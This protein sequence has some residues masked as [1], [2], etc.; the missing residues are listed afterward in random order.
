MSLERFFTDLYYE[1]IHFRDSLQFELQS[2]FAPLRYAKKSFSVSTQEFYLFI[3]S[4]LQINRHT[5]SKEQFY[6]DRTNLIRFKTPEFTFRELI[7]EKN[8][9]SPLHRLDAMSLSI[10]SGDAHLMFQDELKLLANIV[11]SALRVG[12]RSFSQ[13]LFY[14]KKKQVE[15][16]ISGQIM[17]FCKDLDLFRASFLALQKQYVTKGLG[18]YSESVI[19]C[20]LAVDEFISSSVDYYLTGFL[21]Y[22]RQEGFENI[23]GIDLELCRI[24]SQEE[25]HRKETF[26][27]AENIF[28]EDTKSQEQFMHHKSLL[29]KYVADALLL[30]VERTSW[31]EKYGNLVAAFAAGVAM[32]IYVFLVFLNVPYFGINSLS[33]LLVTVVLYV[34]KDRIKDGLKTTFHKRAVLW[35]SDY[36]THIRQEESDKELGKLKEFFSFVDAEDLPEEVVDIRKGEFGADLRFF[37]Q[38]ETIFYYKKQMLISDIFYPKKVRRHKLHNIFL[39]NIHLLLEKASDPFDSFSTLDQHTMEIKSFLLPKVYHLNIVMKNTTTRGDTVHVD[40]KKF[41][42]VLDKNGIKRVE[43]L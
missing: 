20:F 33:F 12:V 40:W 2:D 36:T 11:R 3:P 26:N 7:D 35:F 31:A 27:E 32:L 43:S 10:L 13:E 28:K 18:Q 37:T 39:F 8:T 34:L 5:Y 17:Q 9:L 15:T 14:V 4:A 41:R 29:N 21:E 38:P 23:H 22:I 30:G 25:K 42:L 16:K 24:I 19:E 6:K 1:D